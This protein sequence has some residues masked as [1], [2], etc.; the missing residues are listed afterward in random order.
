MSLI[1]LSVIHVYPAI[2]IIAASSRSALLSMDLLSSWSQSIRDKEFL[3]EMRLR[4][5]DQD[6][7]EEELVNVSHSTESE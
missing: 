4:N 6:T 1:F 3:V 5:H 2:F 7:V